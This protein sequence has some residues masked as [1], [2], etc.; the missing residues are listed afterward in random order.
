MPKEQQ[1]LVEE[2]TWSEVRNTV[3]NTCKELA[4]IIDDIS[5]GKEFTLLK[6]RYPFS[7]K[8]L[9]N[10]EFF[11]PTPSNIST[12]IT[13]NEIDNNIKDK[14]SYSSIPLGIITKNT[15]ELFFDINRKIFPL[16][17]FGNG[18]EIGIWEHFNWT[19]HYN[20]TSGARSLYMLPKISETLSH[21]QL[22]KK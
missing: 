8:I 14:L 10:G 19:S 9:E 11:L 20:I 4:S 2:V 5:P 3:S 18:L 16:A 15:V 6:V 12:P 22:K 17:V 1:T 7:A 21:K 13:S